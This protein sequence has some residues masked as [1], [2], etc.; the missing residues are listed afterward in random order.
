[1]TSSKAGEILRSIERLVERRYLPI[2]GPVRGEVLV[3]LV[4]RVKP[5]RVL[6]V[7]TLLGYSAILIAKELGNEAE[8]VTIEIDEDEAE[9]A[10]ENVRKAEVKPRIRVLV[11]DAL[12][13]IPNLEEEFDLV[14]LDAAK[15]KYFECLRLL[16][17]K[18]N[19]GSLV[20]ADNAG[21][22]AF[23]MREYLEYVRNSGKYESR[24]VEVDGDGIEVSV[25]L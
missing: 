6:E 13:I 24:F 19:K 11:G 21:V 1:V 7:G 16:E 10:K 12:D 25:R 20:V 22:F 4:R 17:D 8:I 15:S 2:I 23:S 9:L 14:F 5:R 3:G 18:L